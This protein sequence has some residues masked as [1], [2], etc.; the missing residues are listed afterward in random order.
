MCTRL[1]LDSWSMKIPGEEDVSQ[2]F[3][4]LKVSAGPLDST[5]RL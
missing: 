5:P 4:N 2:L 3:E 1:C